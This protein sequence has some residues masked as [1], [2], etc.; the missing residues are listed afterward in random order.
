MQNDA[1]DFLRTEYNRTAGSG[2]DS[3]ILRTINSGI[4]NT[5]LASVRST[6]DRYGSFIRLERSTD[7]NRTNPIVNILENTYQRAAGNVSYGSSKLENAVDN[8]E[9]LRHTYSY[10][11]GQC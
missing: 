2:N 6:T 11:L 8:L 7:A 5:V 1:I 3:I 4:A 9:R 10:D